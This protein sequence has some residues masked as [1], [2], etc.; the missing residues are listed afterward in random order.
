VQRAY[1][2]RIQAITNALSESKSS[3]IGFEYYPSNYLCWLFGLVDDFIDGI[4]SPYPVTDLNTNRISRLALL[5][6]HVV[7]LH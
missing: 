4:A 7:N 6:I 5:D 3:F 2:L 1:G